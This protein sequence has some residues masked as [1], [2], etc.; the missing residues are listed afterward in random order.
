MLM[1][2]KVKSFGV[3][4]KIFALGS[5][6]DNS[7]ACHILCHI[8]LHLFTTYFQC[9]YQN[10]QNPEVICKN[11][12]QCE[13]LFYL[14]CLQKSRKSEF[15][16]SIYVLRSH[17]TPINANKMSR[18]YVLDFPHTNCISGTSKYFG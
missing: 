9:H 4:F 12:W 16:Q 14:A 10:Y 8:V 18:L 17:W 2:P 1:S 11:H 13:L 5:V 15:G 7:N 6:I 3:V